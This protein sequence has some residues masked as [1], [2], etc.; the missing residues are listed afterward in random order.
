MSRVFSGVLGFA[1]RVLDSSAVVDRVLEMREM[2]QARL[3]LGKWEVPATR[4]KALDPP[5]GQGCSQSQ[6]NQMRLQELREQRKQHENGLW[7][8]CRRVRSCGCR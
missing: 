3:A 6:W 1:G 4:K 8:L 5:Q 7:C 2:P